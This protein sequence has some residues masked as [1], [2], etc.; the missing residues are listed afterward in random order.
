MINVKSNEFING[1]R[2]KNLPG[3]AEYWCSVKDSEE[4]N[5]LAYMAKE[6]RALQM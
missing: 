6:Y 1:I 5:M 4:A 3:G 2:N